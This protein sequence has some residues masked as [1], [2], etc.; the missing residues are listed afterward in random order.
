MIR[1]IIGT[2]NKYARFLFLLDKIEHIKIPIIYHP[3]LEA[4]TRSF[5]F[6]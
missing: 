2:N 6:H 1:T 5:S 3:S 4:T